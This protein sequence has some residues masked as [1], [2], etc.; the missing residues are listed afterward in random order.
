VVLPFNELEMFM[1]IANVELDFMFA[2]SEASLKAEYE[3][4]YYLNEYDAP[5]ETRLALSENHIDRAVVLAGRAE[6]IEHEC[7]GSRVSSRE[8]YPLYLATVDGKEP[9]I[10]F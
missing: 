7:L 3:A 10:P 2:L 5:F 9:D 4:E 1:N 6:I 8:K